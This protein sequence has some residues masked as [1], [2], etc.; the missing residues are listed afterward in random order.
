MQW[1]SGGLV[2]EYGKP[3]CVGSLVTDSMRDGSLEVLPLEGH[4]EQPIARPGAG[5]TCSYE[6]WWLWRLLRWS[7]FDEFSVVRLLVLGSYW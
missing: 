1:R 3:A 2:V 6:P 4:R 7:I 5:I